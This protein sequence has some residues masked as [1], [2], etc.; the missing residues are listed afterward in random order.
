MS[1]VQWFPPD[2]STKEGA[3]NSKKDSRFEIIRSRHYDLAYWDHEW[4]EWTPLGRHLTW[5]EAAAQYRTRKETGRTD[6][7]VVLVESKTT[8][9][10]MTPL[11]S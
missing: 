6:D 2:Q 7:R 10:D 11:V 8:I 1:F 9:T 3:V 4:E 5:E